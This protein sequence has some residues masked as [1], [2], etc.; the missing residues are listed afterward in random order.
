MP[1]GSGKIQGKR[2]DKNCEGWPVKINR[3]IIFFTVE[4]L[5]V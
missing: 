1:R 2:A 5:R 4:Y 3:L